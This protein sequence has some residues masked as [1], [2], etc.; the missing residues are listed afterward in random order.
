MAM[1]R[2]APGSKFLVAA[3]ADAASNKVNQLAKKKVIDPARLIKGQLL[4]RSLKASAL[5]PDLR[6]NGL[7]VNC[8]AY[9]AMTRYTFFN[10]ANPNMTA[11]THVARTITPKFQKLF[12]CC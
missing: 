10:E 4:I 2:Q 8:V 5:R 7:L 11:R 6:F 9:F 12:S 1:W 3:M